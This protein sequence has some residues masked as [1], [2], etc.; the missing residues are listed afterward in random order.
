MRTS[1]N[2]FFFLFRTLLFFSS[3]CSGNAIEKQRRRG[4]RKSVS[5]TTSSQSKAPLPELVV[6]RRDAPSLHQLLLFA[7][8]KQEQKRHPETTQFYETKSENR[9][10]RG[11]MKKGKNRRKKT[12]QAQSITESSFVH[13]K[14]KR[15]FGRRCG[16]EKREERER[17]VSLHF[18]CG[19][20]ETYPLYFYITK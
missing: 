10:M 9:Q 12:T 6:A 18:L 7:M 20:N 8:R 3:I 1:S 16:G 5:E 11:V 4:Q 19:R 13:T 2:C 14:P 17:G 15:L